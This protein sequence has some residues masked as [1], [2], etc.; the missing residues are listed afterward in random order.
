MKLGTLIDW[1]CG[2]SFVCDGVDGWCARKFN[3]GNEMFV[4]ANYVLLQYLLAITYLLQNGTE[5]V[6]THA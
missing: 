2:L 5:Y 3:Q 1:I 6:H 4:V